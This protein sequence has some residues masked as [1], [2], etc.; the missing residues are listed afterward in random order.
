MVMKRD[1]RRQNNGR[2][3]KSKKRRKEE[4][5][6]GDEE[7]E[8]DGSAQKS[9]KRQRREEQK[10]CGGPANP[11]GRVRNA[12]EQGRSARCQQQQHRGCGSPDQTGATRGPPPSTEHEG[13]YVRTSS[14][15]GQAC[16]TKRKRSSQLSQRSRGR[17]QLPQASN[18]SLGTRAS[19]FRRTNDAVVENFTLARPSAW[20][21]QNDVA[22][23]ANV[24]L[25]L[26][27]FGARQYGPSSPR[28]PPLSRHHLAT[29]FRSCSCARTGLGN[30]ATSGNEGI[31]FLSGVRPHG[32][33]STSTADTSGPFCGIGASGCGLAASRGFELQ[34]EGWPGTEGAVMDNQNRG[35]SS[36]GPVGVMGFPEDAASDQQA[37]SQA[38]PYPTCSHPSSVVVGNP[39][40]ESAGTVLGHLS[41][42]KERSGFG[43]NPPC[44][45]A[46]VRREEG[47]AWCGTYSNS[48]WLAQQGE[49]GIGTSG[50]GDPISG[51][52]MGAAEPCDGFGLAEDGAAS[53]TVMGIM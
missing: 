49:F 15:L 27:G 21:S 12:A 52:G 2:G 4:D 26:A 22:D 6:G 13:H 24:A 44:S 45:S 23:G 33:T 20:A 7:E 1:Y 30:G 50:C 40:F 53:V 37:Y 36:A 5:K 28:P 35:C 39:G 18:D 14:A 47:D 43:G 32:C 34:Q 11:S 8:D 48:A 10:R 19:K 41:P 46:A 9:L 31:D 51:F 25:Q 16:G 29:A 17:V 38:A 3:S 42:V